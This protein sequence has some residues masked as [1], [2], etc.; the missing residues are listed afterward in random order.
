M[1][2]LSGGFDRCDHKS[3]GGPLP[4]S[5]LQP[6]VPGT[7][8]GLPAP[9]G[10][11]TDSGSSRRARRAFQARDY[12]P[13]LG[14]AWAP[15]RVSTPTERRRKQAAVFL[16][17]GGTGAHAGRT[18]FPGP[19]SSLEPSQRNTHNQQALSAQP[20]PQLPERLGL[21]LGGPGSPPGFPISLRA[22]MET[23]GGGVCNGASLGALGGQRTPCVQ[24][25]SSGGV[26]GSSRQWAGNG[27]SRQMSG[28]HIPQTAWRCAA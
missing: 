5:P 22:C 13:H 21:G 23:P 27:S 19:S 26:R 8:R 7:Q 9:S 14:S 25:S 28:F 4:T 1:G 3:H 24:H 20:S 15:G 6:Q 2:R 11:D 17:G 16:L 18:G 12:A 10:V